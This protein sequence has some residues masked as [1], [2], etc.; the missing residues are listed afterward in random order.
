MK[1]RV[2]IYIPLVIFMLAFAALSGCAGMSTEARVS[3]TVY[4]TLNV[5]DAGQ[6]VA[7][8]RS[9][10][11]WTE[12]EVQVFGGESP[13]PG[14][15]YAVMAVGG[16]LHFAVTR[17]LDAQDPGH[18]FWH[19]MSLAWQGVTLG[20]KA[21]FVDDN[22]SHGIKPWGNGGAQRPLFYC[23]PNRGFIK[24]CEGGAQ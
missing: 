21:Y 19:G 4:Q 12:K 7:I 20:G 2:G 14:R 8:G 23:G 18:G 16:I 17:I 5:I 11:V 1:N 9:G 10:G 3:E 15:V 24:A 22:F 6:T 13:R